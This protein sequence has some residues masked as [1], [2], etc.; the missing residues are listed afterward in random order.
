[1]SEVM[2]RNLSKLKVRYPKSF[3]EFLAAHRDL[4]AEHGALGGAN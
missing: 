1:M 3:T 2:E 4:A